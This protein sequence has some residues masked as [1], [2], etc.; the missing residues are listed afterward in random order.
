MQPLFIQVHLFMRTHLQ[1]RPDITPLLH[2]I[3]VFTYR[4]NII[5]MNIKI[6][7]GENRGHRYE[8]Y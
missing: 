8:R 1:V 6:E 5:I 2:Y 3:Y 4:S 7:N